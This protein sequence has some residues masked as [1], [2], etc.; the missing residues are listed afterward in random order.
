MA[1]GQFKVDPGP[2]SVSCSNS[3]LMGDMVFPTAA[4]SETF[5]TTLG[6]AWAA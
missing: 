2:P 5:M 4:T 3:V 6:V 1:W